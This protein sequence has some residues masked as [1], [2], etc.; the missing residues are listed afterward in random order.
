MQR[1]DRH[2]ADQLLLEGQDRRHLVA[3]H[4][5]AHAE[6]LRERQA[7]Q[8]RVDFVR[9]GIGQL[10]V[11]FRLPPPRRALLMAKVPAA[12]AI[13]LSRVS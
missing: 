10:R 8:D 13:S 12:V 4:L 2:I 6:C 5:A 11:H 1:P 9:P 3:E 7:L